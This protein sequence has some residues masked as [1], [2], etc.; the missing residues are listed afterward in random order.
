MKFK[1][2][3][4]KLKLFCFDPK[5]ESRQPRRPSL[6]PPNCVTHQTYSSNPVQEKQYCIS[7]GSEM[8]RPLFFITTQLPSSHEEVGATTASSPSAASMPP[9][10][11]FVVHSD[12]TVTQQSV[13]PRDQLPTCLRT[14]SL[15]G[16]QVIR[17]ENILQI[18]FCLLNT[19]LIFL[20][21]HMSPFHFIYSE[22]SSYV[23]SLFYLCSNALKMNQ[24][25]PLQISPRL[26]HPTLISA[27]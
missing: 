14:F 2:L 19:I 22:R 7:F 27:G 3:L 24:V 1:F 26:A 5:R 18:K 8:H 16:A 12:L 6:Q 21:I 15:H 23:C 13:T 25:L 11:Q 10:A 20:L 4:L 17:S 9:R